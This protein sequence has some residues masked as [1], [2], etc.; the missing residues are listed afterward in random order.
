MN[1]LK[2]AFGV[3]SGKFLGFI[4]RH[5]GIEI[6]P[7]KIKAILE[8]PPPRNL[9]QLRGLQGRLA[10]IRRFIS[11]LSGRC[12][13]F[14]RLMQKTVPFIWDEAC[15]NAF[16]MSKADPLRYILSKPVLSGRLAKWSMILSE[17]E[18]NVVPQK[19]IKGQALAD[20][21]EAHPIPDNME[22]RE[23][24]PDEEAFTI[25]T[26]PWQIFF[27]GA[28][29]NSGAGAGVVF[30]TS[31]GGLIL[32]SLHI[33]T[34]CTHNVAEYEA[35]IIGLKIALE[36]KIQSLEVFGDSLLV[37]KQMSG[38]FAVR[39]ENLIPYHEKAKYLLA[40][41]QE[42]TLNH[43]PRSKNGKSDALAN[44]AASLT[45]P[46]ERDIQITIGECHV[47]PQSMGRIKEENTVNLID[48]LDNSNETDWRQPIKDYIQKGVLPED[49]KKRMD[50]RR[51]APQ[52]VIFNGTLYKLLFDGILLRC[53]SKEETIQAL[54]ETH[55][56]TCGAHQAGPKLSAQLKQLGYY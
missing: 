28:A 32:Y 6:D 33:L 50:V 45:L 12:Q 18:I 27:D 55:A 13:P 51:R 8:M 29:R 35:L 47:L 52:F 39:H 17:F 4:L 21:L 19:A 23:D 14:S 20:F 37:I 53:L 56:G 43:I 42:I 11:N 25:E 9:R 16:E 44:L 5:R 15:Q 48:F 36:I 10:Y 31:S 38:E 46:E 54:Q 49:L 1:P 30:V 26:S 3:A 22:L 41:F 2:C 34:I 24:L 7:A 40:Q